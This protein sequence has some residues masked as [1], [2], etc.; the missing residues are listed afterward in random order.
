MTSEVH[1]DVSLDGQNSLDT[2]INESGLGCAPFF[3]E[4]ILL[5]FIFSSNLSTPYF[6]LNG[7]RSKFTGYLNR[8]GIGIDIIYWY[9]TIVNGYGLLGAFFS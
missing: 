1:I 3:L 7:G 4:I 2:Q 5:L 6:S 9:L 8:S